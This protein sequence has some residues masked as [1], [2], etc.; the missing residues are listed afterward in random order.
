M[1]FCFVLGLSES[2]SV[3]SIINIVD[4]DKFSNSFLPRTVKYPDDIKYGF[5]NTYY[6]FEI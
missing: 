4:S 5:K 6:L 1:L 3:T 2:Y